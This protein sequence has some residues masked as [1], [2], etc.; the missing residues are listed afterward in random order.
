MLRRLTLLCA[1]LCYCCANR[2]VHR[3]VLAPALDYKR[4]PVL[5]KD[6]VAML[7]QGSQVDGLKA[8]RELGLHYTPLEHGLIKT[9]TWYWE[10]GLVKHKPKFLA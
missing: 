5:T 9:L 6:I 8:E 4:P 7:A 3:Q 2:A 1:W 10:E